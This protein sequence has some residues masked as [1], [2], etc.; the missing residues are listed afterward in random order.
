M[1]IVSWNC[2][3]KFR[4]KFKQITACHADI[5]V[6]Q[7][8]ENPDLCSSKA[9]LEFSKNSFWLGVNKNRGIGIFAKDTI[10]MEKLNWN[11]N[12]L[13]YFLPVRINH[14]LDILGVWACKPYI[15]EYYVYQNMNIDKYGLNTMI[16]GDFN[17]NK[18]WDKGHGTRNHSAVVNQLRQIGLESVYHYAYSEA[19]G[20]ETQKTFYLYRHIDK[21]FHI[22]HCFAN[23]SYVKHYSILSDQTWLNYSDHLPLVLEL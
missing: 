18:I 14:Q 7:E 13:K 9:Y 6:I 3:G 5:Y 2:N 20:E 19:Q 11:S 12:G 8:C 10:Y 1:K 15:E 16:I 17:S 21:G 22:D 4:D 23:V